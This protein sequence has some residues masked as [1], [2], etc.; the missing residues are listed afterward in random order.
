MPK[1]KK[2]VVPEFERGKRRGIAHGI[3]IGVDTSCILM[4]LV[5]IDKNGFSKEQIRD[6]YMNVVS[7]AQAVKSGNFKL[8]KMR[9][10]LLNDYDIDVNNITEYV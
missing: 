6:Y 3:K 5:L 8:E 4:L 1:D 2:K 10:V 9:D 7:Y